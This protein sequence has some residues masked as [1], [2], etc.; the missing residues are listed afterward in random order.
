MKDSQRRA[1]WAKRTNR[2]RTTDDRKLIS[3]PKTAQKKLL[4]YGS[5]N[6]YQI[7]NKA[8]YEDISGKF[9]RAPER[10]YLIKRKGVSK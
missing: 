4:A 8:Y 9:L 1:M 2:R 5:F 6:V 10:D 3:L 7:D